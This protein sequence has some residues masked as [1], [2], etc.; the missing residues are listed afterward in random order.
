[1]TVF[2]DL[3]ERLR[4][5]ARA[6]VYVACTGAG[7]GLS[8]LLW[9]VPGASSFLVGTSFP[10]AT[11]A[12]DEFVGFPVEKY[13]SESTAIDLAS[14]A[15]LHAGAGREAVGVG[16]AASV[17]SVRAHRSP[18]R[19]Y[20]ASVSHGG[21]RTYELE[22]ARES[23]RAA[24]AS[25][26]DKADHLA[27]V[28]LLDAVELPSEAAS[29]SVPG[30]T[31]T[32][33][34]TLALERFHTH[35][36]FR[37]DGT[38]QGVPQE[39]ELAFP[40]TFDP[41]HEGHHGMAATVAAVT[42]NKP[43]FWITAEPPHKAAVPLP[44]LLRR[45]RLLRGHDALFTRGEPLYLDK[46]RRYPGCGFVIGTDSLARMLDPKWGPAVDRLVDEFR[47]LGTRFYVTSRVVD[48]KLVTL[49]DVPDAPRDLC[50]EV[51]GRWDVSSTELR[52]A[53]PA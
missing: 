47:I 7:A 19:I 17:A 38:R 23:G 41:P 43:V 31:S 49:G 3:L 35:P 36:L 21:C 20:A 13:C 22:L 8:R 25:D 46:A 48:G 32:N 10:Y 14:A 18:H 16:L 4:D 44:E 51:A 1:M 34:D 12:V 50:I 42:G 30:F 52:R 15:F 29:S 11:S 6:R 33:A 28:A 26:G 37:A 27:F 53:N 24:R 5:E 9:S 39:V 40:G 2:D 45:A